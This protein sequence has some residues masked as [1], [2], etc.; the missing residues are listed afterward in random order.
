MIL[1]TLFIVVFIT[2]ISAIDAYHKNECYEFVGCPDKLEAV[3]GGMQFL[4]RKGNSI[5]QLHISQPEFNEN[6]SKW[7][8][9]LNTENFPMEFLV[10]KSDIKE[11]LAMKIQKDRP[12]HKPLNPLLTQTADII[13][14]AAYVGWLCR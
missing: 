3:R 11:S 1:F 10:G 14:P 5:S 9:E 8:I 12:V 6:D 7:K 13:L 2:T 4:D